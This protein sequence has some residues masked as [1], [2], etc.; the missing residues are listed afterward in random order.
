MDTLSASP[1][2]TTPA[3]RPS[4]RGL[5]WL[6]AGLCLVGLAAYI[7]QYAVFHQFV[8]PW[9]AAIMATVGVGL[10]AVAVMRRPRI[11]RI[12]ALVLIGALTAFEW[13]VLLVGSRVPAYE[14]PAQVGR[15]LPAFTTMRADGRT[16][17][18]QDLR[19]GIPTALIFFR[20]RW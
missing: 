9:Y 19:D 1:P 11:G 3:V 17:T 6:G 14:G 10:M 5:L 18:D 20:G 8:V 12:V 15:P 13:F 4:G 7:I 2:T 16:F